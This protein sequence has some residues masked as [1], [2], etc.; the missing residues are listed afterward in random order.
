MNHTHH[1]K[2]ITIIIVSYIQVFIIY[3]KNGTDNPNAD[4]MKVISFQFQSTVWSWES[5][6]IFGIA[7]LCST[8]RG[9]L[10]FIEARRKGE[11][12]SFLTAVPLEF[13]HSS[14]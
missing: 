12:K 5:M 6:H 10:E 2:D 14:M 7:G 13:H 4:N 1:C 11:E 3:N 9:M 8:E